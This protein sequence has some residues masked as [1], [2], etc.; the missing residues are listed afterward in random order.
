MTFPPDMAEPHRRVIEAI[1]HG[2]GPGI[3]VEILAIP[4][5]DPAVDEL[6]A[7]SW[8]V[9]WHDGKADRVTF[10]PSAEQQL[11]AREAKAE[12]TRLRRE[13]AAQAAR[14]SADAR[15]RKASVR[16]LKLQA[17]RLRYEGAESA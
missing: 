1:A 4:G 17:E 16:L 11:A 8:A 13:N 9:R 12:A 3:G 15:D 5:A 6:V 10:T 7:A 14:K 2:P